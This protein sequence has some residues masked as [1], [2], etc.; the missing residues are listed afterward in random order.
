MK[1]RLKAEP[2]PHPPARPDLSGGS[3][4]HDLPIETNRPPKAAAARARRTRALQS[5][6]QITKFN[7]SAEGGPQ[8]G[9]EGPERVNQTKARPVGP[10][11][12]L[13][14]TSADLWEAPA[15]RRQRARSASGEG[16]EEQSV[17]PTLAPPQRRE[18]RFRRKAKPG[19]TIAL[20]APL[21]AAAA[22]AS[23]GFA[24]RRNLGVRTHDAILEASQ[25][26]SDDHSPTRPSPA[27]G[28]RATVSPKGETWALDHA[29]SHPRAPAGARATG[30]SKGET[31]EAKAPEP[32][33][34]APK[35]R[36]NFGL[37]SHQND[38]I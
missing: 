36:R 2:F 5:S 22:A 15:T 29:K 18:P 32:K 4:S 9:S 8:R 7:R 31:W 23:H 28:R 30:S 1:A 34:R 25:T 13:N 10:S 3:A 27:E 37:K 20:I 38:A 12:Y 16:A 33:A 35:F 17:L 26:S 14:L 6:Q 21:A 24:E 19:R 11:R